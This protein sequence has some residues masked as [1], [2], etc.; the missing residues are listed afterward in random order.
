MLKVLLAAGPRPL[1]LILRSD[2]GVEIG[3]FIKIANAHA[4][5]ELLHVFS[6]T[7]TNP[8]Q[9]ALDEEQLILISFRIEVGFN[10]RE[11]RMPWRVTMAILEPHKLDIGNRNRWPLDLLRCFQSQVKVLKLLVRQ[12]VKP[13]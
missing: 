3:A 5:K 8:D 9:T 12:S 13:S 2:D 1:S 11:H 10:G 6:A 4:T 7:T